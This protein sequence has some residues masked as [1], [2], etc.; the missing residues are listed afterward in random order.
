MLLGTPEPFPLINPLLPF[1]SVSEASVGAAAAASCAGFS[2]AS[3]GVN[4]SAPPLNIS[5]VL[6]I[7]K[8]W[9]PVPAN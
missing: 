9:T 6:D 1:P 7:F 4:A 3:P 8:W 2:L 5:S